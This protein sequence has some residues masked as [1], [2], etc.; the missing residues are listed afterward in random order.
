M[1][2]SEP[3]TP[4]P[5]APA[6][7]RAVHATEE[8]SAADVRVM[9]AAP[10]REGLLDL[11]GITGA[12]AHELLPQADA[13]AADAELLAEVTT[14]ANRL[15]AEAGLE[16]TA[17]DLAADKERLDALQQR[18]L[19]GEGL[20]VILAAVVSTATVRAW[21]TARGLT[22][23]QSWHVLADLG[24]QM[25]V[26]RSG[27]GRLGLHQLNWVSLNWAGRLVHLGRL[28]FDLHRR[29]IHGAPERWVLGTHIPATGP[30]DPSA[31]EESF[32]AAT[33]YFTGH[34]PE[35]QEDRG[36]D[37]PRFGHEFVCDSWLRSRGR[38][39]TSRGSR[40]CGTGS[41]C[42]RT[43]P[44]V[45]CSSPSVYVRRWMPAP[46]LAA[47]GSSGRWR[48]GGPMGA[49]GPAGW[50]T[51]CADRIRGPRSGGSMAGAVE[52]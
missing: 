3:V 39:R 37:A 25:R 46:S 33:A 41:R 21:H 12:D 13:V 49:A 42:R 18:L 14:I 24:Q 6:A 38:S 30:L 40:R 4:A 15:R 51:W 35:L 1:P 10:S 47:P 26:H 43:R 7:P 29:A 11:L 52:K 20:L 19:P 27:T 50:G 5:S 17:V 36:P 8:L 45:R 22:T 23:E 9:L 48:I 16:T 34:Y 32:A 28:Q 31:V 2:A 44:M